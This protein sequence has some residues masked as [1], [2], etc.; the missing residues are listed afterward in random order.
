MQNDDFSAKSAPGKDFWEAVCSRVRPYVHRTPV[1]TSSALDSIAGC[2]IFFKCENLQKIGAFKMRGAVNAALCLPEDELSKGLAT[3]SSG[4]FAQAVALSARKLGVPA[5]IVMPENAPQVKKDAVRGYGAQVVECEPT[6]E[7]RESAL[8]K[9]VFEKGMTA[10]H[11]YND[12]NVM[13]GQGTAAVELH[14]DVK[15]LD[16]ILAPVGGGGLMS[17][18]AMATAA[19]APQCVPYGAEPALAGDAVLSLRDG[20]IHPAFPPRTIAD[21]LR[22]ALGDKTLFTL[23]RYL[24][25]I[26]LTD[27]DEI[28]GAMRLVWE[29]MK[30]IIEPSSAVPLAAVLRH[31]EIFSKARVGIILSG[32]NVDASV[33]FDALRSKNMK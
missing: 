31:P 28:T 14:E 13:Y 2:N 33:F 9:V 1:M 15:G 17:G 20:T 18:T 7:A 16:F 5:C 30:I 4:N 29:R 6:Q 21:G 12:W 23:R 25:D 3:H 19:F 32:G 26:L 24:R 8:E 27:E 22:T 10:L 11:P